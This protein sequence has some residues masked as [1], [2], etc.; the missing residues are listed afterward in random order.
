MKL[1][2][3]VLIN[4]AISRCIAAGRTPKLILINPEFLKKLHAE[5]GWEQAPFITEYSYPKEVDDEPFKFATVEMRRSIFID[6]FF[7]VDDR[8][9]KEQTWTT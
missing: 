3:I 2:I 4:E 8:S 1:K 5:L 7:I 9:G 6:D